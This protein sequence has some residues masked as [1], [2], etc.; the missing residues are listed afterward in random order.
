MVL[1]AVINICLLMMK[2]V[3]YIHPLTRDIQ[4]NISI[5]AVLGAMVGQLL[6]GIMGDRVSGG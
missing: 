1:A 6:F 2:E 3:D 5:M 4:A